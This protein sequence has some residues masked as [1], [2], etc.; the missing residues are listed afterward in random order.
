[1]L[2]PGRRPWEPLRREA[3]ASPRETA[4]SVR[5]DQSPWQ[6]LVRTHPD[7]TSVVATTERGA[8]LWRSTTGSVAGG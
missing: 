7:V 8:D 2:A 1:M 4:R 3:R 5:A 6:I